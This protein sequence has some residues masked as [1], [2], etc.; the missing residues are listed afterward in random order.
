MK[1]RRETRGAEANKKLTGPRRCRQDP[2]DVLLARAADANLDCSRRTSTGVLFDRPLDV[3]REAV[4]L[5]GVDRVVTF[6]ALH[7]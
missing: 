1:I 4:F 5:G 3:R 2:A 7:F 6:D